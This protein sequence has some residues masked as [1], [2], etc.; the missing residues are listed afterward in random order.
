MSLSIP[1]IKGGREYWEKPLL[2]TF[3]DKLGEQAGDVKARLGNAPY[4]AQY[5]SVSA[6]CFGGLEESS[7]PIVLTTLIQITLIFHHEEELY[8]EQRRE[9]LEMCPPRS[10]NRGDA[11]EVVPVSEGF[12][13][14]SCDTIL[15]VP[16]LE[17]DLW[18]GCVEYG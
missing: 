13:I 15:E 17:I 4:S 5:G 6:E 9:T 10:A 8:A 14:K 3:N 18:V 11:K 7:G 1:I 16:L 2:L 12:Y